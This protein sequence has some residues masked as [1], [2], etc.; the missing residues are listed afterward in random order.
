MVPA[1]E[2]HL[3]RAAL[4]FPVTTIVTSAGCELHPTGAGI[5][6]SFGYLLSAVA[7][8]AGWWQAVRHA[9]PR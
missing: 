8:P 9:A 2:T 6:R 1:A 5:D 3:Q 7:G 4:R